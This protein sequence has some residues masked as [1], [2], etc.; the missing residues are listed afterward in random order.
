M[1]IVFC[2][3]TSILSKIIMW[4]LNE[5]VSHFAI[6]MDKNLVF[7][8]NLFGVNIQGD[9]YFEKS[10]KIVKVID[11]HATVEQENDIYYRVVDQ[12]D[13]TP[14]DWRTF[15]YFIW[16]AILFRVFEST[17]PVTVPWNTTTDQSF[18]C[19]RMA[20]VLPPDWTKPLL[21]ADILISPWQMYLTMIKNFPDQA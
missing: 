20:F 5:P 14:Y 11:P 13:G 2:A 6:I 9:N 8:S 18:L 1:K 21:P 10:H 7:H 17:I 3:G 19:T 16:R 12:L 4:G 15:F